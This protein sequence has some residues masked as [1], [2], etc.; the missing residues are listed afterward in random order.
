ME[1]DNR[2]ED[3]VKTGKTLR[4]SILTL[5]SLGIATLTS[6]QTVDTLSLRM[7]DLSN[8]MTDWDS[9]AISKPSA[10]IDALTNPRTMRNKYDKLMSALAD[11]T[12]LELSRI[13]CAFCLTGNVLATGLCAV[14]NMGS[15][16]EAIKQLPSRSAKRVAVEH[17][18]VTKAD[19]RWVKKPIKW[20]YGLADTL[21]Q[22]NHSMKGGPHTGSD[23]P[24]GTGLAKMSPQAVAL[25]IEHATRT[26]SR[27]RRGLRTADNYE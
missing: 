21:V 1:L 4:T 24:L 25:V 18:W 23:G 16:Y 19:G 13:D 7:T 17:E 8:R 11:R 9:F 20:V 6:R 10:V 14:R 2:V 26:P 15:G 12:V 3:E 27:V 22:G 5:I